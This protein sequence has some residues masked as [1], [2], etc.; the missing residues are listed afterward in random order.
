M[1][2][3]AAGPASRSPST[4][5]GASGGNAGKRAREEELPLLHGAEM[6]QEREEESP[7]DA[8]GGDGAVVGGFES[9]P[10]TATAPLMVDKAM[11]CCSLCSLSL[12]APIYQC[13]AGHLACCTCRVKLPDGGCRTCCGGAAAYAHCPG[14]D[15]FFARVQVPCPYAQYGCGSYVPYPK[16]AAHQFACEHAPCFCPEAGCGFAGSPPVL[17]A[18]LAGAH[19]WPVDDVPYGTSVQLAVPVPPPDSPARHCRLLVGAGD[20]SVFLI[21][22]G[23]LGD[24]AA[25]SVVRVRANPPP[26]PRFTCKLLANSPP[27]EADADLAGGYYFATVPVRSSALVYGGGTVPEKGLYFAVPREMLRQA[28]TPASP[29]TVRELLVSVCIDRT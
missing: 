19:S 11:L 9:P 25:V 17:L 13:A 18:H 12:K 26:Q 5:R 22:V 29:S 7:G 1:A 24:G 20:A 21:A 8:A 3:P 27:E 15:A 16:V 23:P 28:S 4:E 10:A 6:K 2:P 14:L